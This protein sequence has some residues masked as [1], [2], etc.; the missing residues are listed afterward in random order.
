MRTRLVVL[1]GVAVFTVG[2]AISYRVFL[3]RRIL[4]W[5]A[6][7]D[8]VDATLPGDDLLPSPDGQ[9]TR[10]ITVDAPPSDVFPWLAQMGP[11]P[12]GGGYPYE[13][14]ENLFHLNMHSVDHILEEY[15]QPRLGDVIEFGSNR[16]VL[17][18]VDPPHSIA[19]RSTD[20]N[21]LWAFTMRDDASGRTR[22]IS[23][24]R[25]RLPRLIDRVG[26]IP[27]EPGSLVMERKML[28][29]IGQRAEKLA[30][31]R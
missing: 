2:A 16:M 27:M 18:L 7:P 22:L 25:F 8:E 6:T 24:N 21:W 14:N 17:Q 3:R 11:A 20:G 13:W 10:A 12:R 28:G 29:E 4:T 23:R 15:Q 1:R 9:S 30:R 5:G 31:T 26:M 19:W